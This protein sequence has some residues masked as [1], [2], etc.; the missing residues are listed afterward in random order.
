MEPRLAGEH[1]SLGYRAFEA[2]LVTTLESRASNRHSAGEIVALT[3]M[4]EGWF[5]TAIRLYFK[6]RQ[7]F[8]GA[9]T[10]T[11][12]S[13]RVCRQVARDL[14]TVLGLDPVSAHSASNP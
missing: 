5:L 1:C 12:S 9:S 13:Q 4:A 3:E 6:T 10:S 2:N 7:A 14:A 8:A 11:R